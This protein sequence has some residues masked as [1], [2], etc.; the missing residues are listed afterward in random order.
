MANYTMTS[1]TYI[2]GTLIATL[3][4]M[5]AYIETIDNTKTIY[6]YGVYR[7]GEDSYV[8]AIVHAT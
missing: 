6:V 8:G 1:T 3:A 2:R 5:E 4:A 7:D